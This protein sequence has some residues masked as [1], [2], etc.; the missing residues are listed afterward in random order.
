MCTN[1]VGSKLEISANPTPIC[2]EAITDDIFLEIWLR[3]NFADARSFGETCPYLN[4]RVFGAPVGNI[5]WVFFVKRRFPNLQ[6]EYVKFSGP[7]FY[8]ECCL[9]ENSILEK[10][11]KRGSSSQWVEE[12]DNLDEYNV[13]YPS[14]TGPVCTDGKGHFLAVGT[15]ANAGTCICVSNREGNVVKEYSI[16]PQDLHIALP[17][18]QGN[19]LTRWYESARVGLFGSDV[20][21]QRLCATDEHVVALIKQGKGRGPLPGK[22]LIWDRNSSFRYQID[23]E[24]IVDMQLKEKSLGLILSPTKELERRINLR[25][26]DLNKVCNDGKPVNGHDLEKFVECYSV[27]YCS[28]GVYNLSINSFAFK[29]TSKGLTLFLQCGRESL[30][31]LHVINVE[32]SRRYGHFDYWLRPKSPSPISHIYQKSNF[33]AAFLENNSV[34]FFDFSPFEK[35]QSEIHKKFNPV[36]ENL[37]SLGGLDL[38]PRQCFEYFGYNNVLQ[39]HN[40]GIM[41]WE[42]FQ[43]ILNTAPQIQPFLPSYDLKTAKDFLMNLH[44]EVENNIQQWNNRKR[45]SLVVN[46]WESFPEKIQSL[47]ADSDICMGQNSNN[48]ALTK[49]NEFIKEYNSA[50]KIETLQA[51]IC[52]PDRLCWWNRWSSNWDMQGMQSLSDPSRPIGF[53]DSFLYSL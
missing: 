32:N 39:L 33:L 7:H 36:N 14:L 3:C 4:G 19:F 9:L 45:S 23:C 21:I 31:S 52:A 24:S 18:T 22:V 37:L 15:D 29:K 26:L 35:F 53:F 20:F 1:A 43:M 8:R 5:Q 12:C 28:L 30:L 49:L 50:I 11:L 42:D 16:S 38:S 40:M 6:E 48:E 47:L 25:I 51:Y 44:E 13:S 27:D 34:E 17:S 46:P 41:S 2:W 10:N